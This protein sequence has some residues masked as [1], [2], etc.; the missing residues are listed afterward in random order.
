MTER[1]N[2]EKVPL[3]VQLVDGVSVKDKIWHDIAGASSVSATGGCVNWIST[4]SSFLLN[5][6]IKGK[7]NLKVGRNKV[8]RRF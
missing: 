5:H 2:P 4:L 8:K 3:P 7:G 1:E 6:T